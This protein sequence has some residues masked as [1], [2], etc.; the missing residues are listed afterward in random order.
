MSSLLKGGDDCCPKHNFIPSVATFFFFSCMNSICGGHSACVFERLLARDKSFM[1]GYEFNSIKQ[2]CEI[3]L[4]P[5]KMNIEFRTNEYLNYSVKQISF[6]T[7]KC[8]SWKLVEFAQIDPDGR[9]TQI[10]G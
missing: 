1:F 3:V 4:I 2:L 7:T 9:L 8:F 5:Y 10:N 6:C